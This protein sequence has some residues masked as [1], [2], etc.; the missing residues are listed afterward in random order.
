MKG[1]FYIYKWYLNLCY[2]LIVYYF[3]VLSFYIFVR[4]DLNTCPRG[5]NLYENDVHTLFHD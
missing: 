5:G 3:M 2:N 4:V 1:S